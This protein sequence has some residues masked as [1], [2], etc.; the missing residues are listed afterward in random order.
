MPSHHIFKILNKNQ[1]QIEV[2][3]SM[4]HPEEQCMI[5]TTNFALQI[6]V[7][8]YEKI[9]FGQIKS[10]ENRQYFP[11]SQEEAE[12]LVNPENIEKLDKLV[13]AMH[14]QT[15]PVSKE[16][17]L[18]LNE[19][20]YIE[21]EDYK[22]TSPTSSDGVYFA[23]KETNHDLFCE[24]ADRRIELVEQL[25]ISNY[26]HWYN[27][28]D[29]WLK[30]GKLG[31]DIDEAEYEVHKNEPNPSYVLKITVGEDYRFLL[32]HL[33][34]GS[35]WGSVA[36]DFLPNCKY[37]Y[38]FKNPILHTLSYIPKNAPAPDAELAQWWNQLSENWRVAF[39]VNLDFQRRMI[40]P[41]MKQNYC[42]MIL[43]STYVKLEGAE[44][45]NF[46]KSY[47]PTVEELR[48]ISQLSIMVI[49]GMDFENLDPL[50]MLKGLRIIDS[51]ENPLKNLD[52]IKELTD[53][54]YLTVVTYSK[55]KPDHLVLSN[56]TK[57]RELV[58][59]PTKQEELDMLGEFT[60]LRKVSLTCK[61]EADLSV[62]LKLK[63]LKTIIG[64]D[65]EPA[66]ASKRALIEQLRNNGVEVNW[67]HAPK[68]GE[69]GT[70]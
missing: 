65:R 67:D 34:I 44:K 60:Y 70:Y 8:G 51:E 39:L 54:E 63:N 6:L 57:L 40:Y 43:N 46:F 45:F 27:R 23:C 4:V 64:S 11:L 50:A 55:P 69:F 33:I 42:G 26:P 62:L 9:K 15:I 59:D 13:E 21:T 2:E 47:K 20:G 66:S 19:K 41:Q 16:E 7:E 24:K 35:F 14:C 37:Y 58:I 3:I 5:T 38:S 61:F 22:L 31:N 29:S 36:Y 32:D 68:N 56:L 49:S 25:S 12:K 48:L 10:I 17:Y 52:G 30:F 53:L 1:N 18:I 28:M